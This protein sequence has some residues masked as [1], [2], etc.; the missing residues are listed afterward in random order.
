MLIYGSWVST[1]NLLLILFFCL[2][3]TE[4]VLLDVIVKVE[5]E[6]KFK[7]KNKANLFPN[8]PKRCT[9]KNICFLLIPLYKTLLVCQLLKAINTYNQV[10][11]FS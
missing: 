5:E 11:L 1:V 4:S 6:E 2:S 7:K 3:F 9:I 10:I 8:F